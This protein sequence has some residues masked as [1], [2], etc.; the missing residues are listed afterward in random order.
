MPE[1][2]AEYDSVRKDELEVYVPKAKK[3][4]GDIPRIVRFT[5]NNGDVRVGVLNE[6]N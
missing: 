5:K 4:E 3:Y 2:V 1:N 6:Q